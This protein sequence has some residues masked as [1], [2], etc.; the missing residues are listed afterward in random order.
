MTTFKW[1]KKQREAVLSLAEGYSI[2]EV[3]AKVD[4]SESQ[5]Y[6]WRQ[7]I[8]FAK[9]LDRLSNMLFTASKAERLRITHRIVRKAMERENPTNKDILEWLKFAQSETDG[10]KLDLTALLDNDPPMAG[11]GSE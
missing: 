4:I 3:L 7:N 10:I 11:G 8:D 6:R 9:E 2:N 1:N 5:L